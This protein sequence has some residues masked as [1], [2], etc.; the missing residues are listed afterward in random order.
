MNSSANPPDQ[1]HRESE[2]FNIAMKVRISCP[3][4]SAV[5]CMTRNISEGGVYVLTTECDQ[6]I[7][8]MVQIEKIKGQEVTVN[9]TNNTAIVVHKDSEGVGLAFVDLYLE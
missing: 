9:L 2:R 1:D 6:S 8:E 3:D 7:G 4:G 5:E